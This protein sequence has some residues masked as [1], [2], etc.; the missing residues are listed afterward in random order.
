[1]GRPRKDERLLLNRPLRVMLTAEQDDLIRQAA[2]LEGM[3]VAAWARPLLTEAAR[4]RVAKR[5]ARRQGKGT[6]E[7]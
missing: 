4:E 7:G 1:M 2:K 5:K 3:D 6:G